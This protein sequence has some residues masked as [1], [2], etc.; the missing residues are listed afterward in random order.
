MF[1]EG[2]QWLNPSFLYVGLLC[3][4]I[5]LVGTRV[6]HGSIFRPIREKL[7]YRLL[8][9]SIAGWLGAWVL[10]PFGWV[11]VPEKALSFFVP[12]T[13]FGV[14][15]MLPVLNHLERHL[16]QAAGLVW[17]AT[18]AHAAIWSTGLLVYGVVVDAGV[19]DAFD[20]PRHI[21]DIILPMVL[22]IPMGVVFGVIVF[23]AMSR[24]LNL[25]FDRR[26]W[27]I[28]IIISAVCGAIYVGTLF[29]WPE[30]TESLESFT[31]SDS[32]MFFAYILWYAATAA[33]FD[34]GK[35]QP[36]SPITKY[37]LGLL[38]GLVLLTIWFLW[39]FN[40]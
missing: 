38:G 28:A 1:T 34:L 6:H 13:L 39:Q 40:L 27:F 15:V 36:H 10:L 5:L 4:A 30:W 24:I 14:L 7:L 21:E 22:G 20:L 9:A 25:R 8:L 31:F 32:P 18:V 2:P 19:L 29:D 11:P 33:V 16:L 12:G 3:L 35:P 17:A 23:V 37:D 26:G